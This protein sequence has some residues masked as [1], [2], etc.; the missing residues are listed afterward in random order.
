M[1]TYELTYILSPDFTIEEAEAKAKEYE[2]FIQEKDGVILRAEKVTPKTLSFAIKKQGTGFYTVL[3][4]Q[5]LPEKL[6][7][8]KNKIQIDKKV[9]RH[10]ILSYNPNKKFMKERRERKKPATIEEFIAT[11]EVIVEKPEA[12]EIKEE[13]AIKEPKK[14]KKEKQKVELNDIEKQLDEILSE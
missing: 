4:F 1:K 2:F 9:L 11:K 12:K 3:E 5:L 14:I 6:I 13:K 7:E 8:L 10:I